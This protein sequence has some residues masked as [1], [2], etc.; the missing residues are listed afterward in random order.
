MGRRSTTG[1][2]KASGDRIEVRFTYRGQEVRPTLN[3]RPTE[4]N[5]KHARRMRADIVQQIKD[6]RFDLAHHFPDYK[7]LERHVQPPSV[8]LFATVADRFVKWVSTRQEHSSVLSLKR[9]LAYFW[10]PKFGQCDIRTI[11]FKQLSDRVSERTWG[12]SKTHNNYVSALRE[13]FAYAFDH[14]YIDENPALKLKMLKVQ[15]TDP[16]PYTVQEAQTLI[17]VARRVHGDLDASYWEFAFLQGM[18]PGEQISVK[19]LDWNRI[20]GRLTVQR[21]LTEGESKES[22][23]T[24][25]ARHMDLAPRSAELLNAMSRDGEFIFTDYETGEQIQRST[26]MQERWALLHKVADVRYREPYQCRHSSVSWKLMAGENPLKVAKNHGHSMATMF[27]TYAHWVDTECEASEL[28]RIRAFHGWSDSGKA[29][30][31]RRD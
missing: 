22:T 15:R 19:W 3:L 12:S 1:G 26:V 8:T 14:E 27:K 18:R 11:S 25:A 2:V 16:D 30:E 10:E 21:M 28:Q 31:R 13:M 24:H 29:A 20:T 9:K 4:S 5:L 6:G 17:S 7:F 23:K